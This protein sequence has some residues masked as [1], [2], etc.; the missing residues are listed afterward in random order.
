MG[1]GWFESEWRRPSGRLVLALL[2]LG[3]LLVL[4]SLATILKAA[5]STD[6]PGKLVARRPELTWRHSAPAKGGS[7]S[8]AVEDASAVFEV[9]NI[10]DRPVRVVSV[11]ASCGCVRPSVQPSV[12]APH[13][14]GLVGVRTTAFPVG[15]QLATLKLH[16]DSPLTPTVGLR[17]RTLGW[18]DPPFLIRATGDLIYFG[19]SAVT[20]AREICV[21]S[22]ELRGT[23]PNPPA[24]KSD[25][26]FLTVALPKIDERPSSDGLGLLRTYRHE[27]TLSSDPPPPAKF[28]GDV[29]IT[30]PW[31]SE[32]VER[33]HVQ[34]D[35]PPP[36]R[37]YP[38]RIILR[39]DSVTS[40]ERGD[41]RLTVCSPGATSRISAVVEPEGE[42]PLSI[43]RAGTDKEGGVSFTITLDRGKLRRDAEY[44]II[45]RQ[46]PGSAVQ[47]VVPVLV[48]K[49]DQR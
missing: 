35:T 30:D 39:G 43:H 5:R 41:A 18:R 38:S 15:E 46:S 22:A 33:L 3:S 20:E 12:I 37:V 14:M 25:L 42:T 4:G 40:P 11:E 32:H 1:S 8:A 24:I 9:E 23:K 45:I 28:G 49:G 6:S 26:R 13:E 29:L 48:Q 7:K 31:D 17:L 44:S 36:L 16:T 27:V 2:G 47:V 21:Y 34:G 10:G 19:G